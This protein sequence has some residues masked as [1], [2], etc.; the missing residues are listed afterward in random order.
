MHHIYPGLQVSWALTRRPRSGA[1]PDGFCG[2]RSP[3]QEG[4]RGT[5]VSPW[6]LAPKARGQEASGFHIPASTKS[7]LEDGLRLP[8]PT[9]Q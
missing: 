8:R 5:A 3:R 6:R 9:P 1:G 2:P 4:A 7:V